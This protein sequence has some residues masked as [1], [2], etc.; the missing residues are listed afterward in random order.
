MSPEPDGA[1]YVRIEG[2]KLVCGEK[3]HNHDCK[4]IVAAF[5]VALAELEAREIIEENA[6][7]LMLEAEVKRDAWWKSRGHSEDC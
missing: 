2:N 7:R 6:K 1:H 4:T 3:G 5:R